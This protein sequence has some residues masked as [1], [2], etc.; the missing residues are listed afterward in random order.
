M[1]RRT[2]LAAPATGLA[3][4]AQTS[5]RVSAAGDGIPHSPAEF[6]QLL[7]K[8][9]ASG[10][11]EA[12]D[13]SRGGA[14]AAVEKRMAARLG[15]PAAIWMPTGTLA[16]HLAV[17]ALAG[18]RRRVLV[19]AE[20]HLYNDSGDC[21]Q[22][23]SALHLV[24]LAAGRATFTV[25]DLDRAWS[26]AESGRVAAPIGAL[27]VETPVRRRS[28]ERFAPESLAAVTAWAR[29]RGVGLHLDGARLFVESAYSGRDVKDYAAAFDTVYISMYKCFNS[30]SGAILAGPEALLRD[31][32]HARRM[33]G[34]GLAAA[35]PY[36]LAALHF[37]DTF[38]ASFAAARKTSE[39]A[40]AALERDA[41]FAVE[42]I[43]NGTNIF[44]LKASSVNAPVFAMRLEEA[45]ISARTPEQD[46][47]TLQVNPTW[48]RVPAAEI[49][50]RFRRALG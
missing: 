19:Q 36:A 32:H 45:G 13:Y 46:W 20:S 33:F 14:V 25:E 30:G 42:R 28:G 3:L 48:A 4:G 16:N 24:P 22:T 26:A 17:R 47:F 40:I 21:A 43:P 9:T 11:V 35:W 23:L 29:S 31:M 38:E 27:Q 37:I 41:N 7:A 34:G 50:A 6:A 1:H 49:V 10:G 8:L 12:D 18:A 5:D 15:K 44:R 2:F 39:E